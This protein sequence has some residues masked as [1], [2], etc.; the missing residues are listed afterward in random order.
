MAVHNELSLLVW[1]KDNR[2]S[3]KKK[4]AFRSTQN[5]NSPIKNWA[6][7]LKRHFSEEDIQMVNRHK[8]M[9]IIAKY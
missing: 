8:K 9:L 3:K 2:K 5:Q 7:V 1:F 6:E 4:K